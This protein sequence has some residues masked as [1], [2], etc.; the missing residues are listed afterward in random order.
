[1]HTDVPLKCQ[2]GKIQGFI[3][4][5]SDTDKIHHTCY[6][7]DCQAYAHYLHQAQRVLNDHGGTEIVHV[8]PSQMEFTQ[9][10]A[11][12]RCL[13]LSPKGTMR[14]YAGCCRTPI[15]NTARTAKIPHVGVIHTFIDT[16]ALGKTLSDVAGPVEAGVQGKFGIGTLPPGTLQTTSVPVMLTILGF[17]TK[18][19]I[20]QGQKPNPFFDE[21]TGEPLAAPT[22][23]TPLER[24][25]LRPLTGPHPT[26]AAYAEAHQFSGH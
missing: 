16:K 23:L 14:W 26:Q 2:C 3:R 21:K 7:D 20:H 13:M 1:M 4:Q 11:E 5:L 6:C 8:M 22:V 9:G 19:L 17:F 24:D 18:A 12:V 15:G 10:L 25:S